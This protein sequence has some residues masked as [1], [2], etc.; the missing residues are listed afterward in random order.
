[1]NLKELRKARADKAAR[2]KAA[3]AEYNALSAKTDR[4]EA[5]DGRVAALDAE[6]ETLESEVVALDEQIAAEERR[7]RRAG[8]FAAPAIVVP[9]GAAARTVN[10][11]GPG[12]GGFKSMT[13]FGAAV[14][15][16]SMNRGTDA[17]LTALGA[18]ELGAAPTN[19][20]QNVGSAGEGFL[21]PPDYRTEIW[22]LVFE[23][24]D[25]IDMCDGVRTNSNFVSMPKDETTPWGATGVQAAWRA[26]GLQVTP[27][28]IAM[29][30]NTVQ[31]HELFAFVAATDELLAD[32]PRLQNMMTVQA[33]RAI[34]WKASDA[35][36]WGD[37]NGKPLGYQN[38]GALVVVNKDSGQL[39]GT[40]SVNNLLTMMSRLFRTGGGSPFW[41]INPDVLPQLGQL[42]IGN[43]P[44]WLPNPQPLVGSPW[45][46]TLLGRPVMFSEH[47]QSLSTQGDINLTSLDIGYMLLTKAGGGIDYAASIHLW[48]DYNIS[49]FRWVF[50][51]GG[52]PYLSAPVT[53]AHG[54]NSKSHFVTLQAR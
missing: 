49:A 17:R 4:T 15:N 31:L 21:V 53:P 6:L 42:T 41:T 24:T 28:K 48:F 34:R 44:A 35:V 23:G 1:M 25:F 46:G 50:R 33:A 7:A 18:L 40:V 2:G 19:F 10:E 20:E 52:Q 16:A 47:A 30:Q 8:L 45:E 3:T 54:S 22:N 5:E 13:E 43:F 14:M 51:L 11:P 9:H 37:G 12:T 38:A 36:I 32:A 27:S 29:G 39:T 26:E